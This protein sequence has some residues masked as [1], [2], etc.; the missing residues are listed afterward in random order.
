M[1]R[2]NNGIFEPEAP[3]SFMQ[4]E[5]ITLITAE[6]SEAAKPREHPTLAATKLGNPLASAHQMV[7]A[8][9]T[10]DIKS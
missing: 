10:N 8:K 7:A 5:Q 2:R 9:A 1:A 4:E 6:S 3:T